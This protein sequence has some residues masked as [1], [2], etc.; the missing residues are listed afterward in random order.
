MIFRRLFERKSPPDPLACED[1]LTLQMLQGDWQCSCCGEWFHGI[2]DLTA[3][4]PDPWSYGASHEPNSALRR[5][6][7][8]LSEDFCVLDGEHFLVRCVLE[9]P[10]CGLEH[11]WGFGCWSSLS[12]ENFEEYVEGFDSGE[13]EDAGPWFGWLCNSLKPHLVD[14]VAVDV[15]PR[16]GQQRPRLLVVDEDHPIAVAQRKGLSARDLLEILRANGHGPTIQ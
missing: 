3:D 10:V 9:F 5:D 16:S 4:H 2:T 7:D 6:G 1:S 15:C 14:P 11:S 8:F 13:Y 12:R